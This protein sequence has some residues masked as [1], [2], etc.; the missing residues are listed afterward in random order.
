MNPVSLYPAYKNAIN[1]T[2][3][4]TR[5]SF[6][7]D[8]GLIQISF[9]TDNINKG[10]DIIEYSNKIFLDQRV[11][12]QTEKSRA[13][14]TFIDENLVGSQKIVEQNKEKLKE[15]LEINKSIDLDLETQVIIDTVKSIDNELYGI[16]VELANASKIYTA[17][18]SVY[19]NL[20][21]KKKILS[22]QKENILSKIKVM[23]KEQQEYIDLFNQ[24]EI[25]QNLLEELETRRL[26]FSILEASTIGD[27]RIVDSAYLDDM[28]SPRLLTVFIF[29]IAGFMLSLFIAII[30]GAN[31]LPIT[32]PAE[33]MDNGMFQPLLG[34]IP[35]EE[36]IDLVDLNSDVSRY[37]AAMESTIINIRSL[38]ND[39]DSGAKIIALTSP[40]PLNGKSTTSKKLAETLSL[41]G[42]KVLLV[43]ADFKRG[44]LNKDFNVKSISEETFYSINS[45]NLNEYRVAENFYLIPRVKGLMNSFHFICS[46][47]YPKTFENLRDQFDYII[48]DTAPLLSVADTSV[49]LKL[50]DINLLVTRHEVNKIREIKQTIDMFNQINVTL[51][52]FIYNAYAKPTGYYGYYQLYGNY[53]Y[54]YYSDRYLNDSYEYKNK[55]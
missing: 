53:A 3:N 6:I 31:F 2:A 45:N 17:N 14:I 27:I 43:D 38:Q 23:P 20:I 16:E 32:N 1:V 24:V 49:I 18:N 13:A 33:I 30:R 22:N 46:D 8:E 34:V 12:A 19:I 47:R 40:T 44:G 41:L 28:V 37:K 9:V 42:K 21:N 10:I 4:T 5:N 51:D 39:D 26:G 15:F 50:A 7:R 36:N 55:A 29:T 25:T 52:G 11:L 48:F 35:L 54:A